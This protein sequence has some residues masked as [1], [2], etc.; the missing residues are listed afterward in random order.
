MSKKAKIIKAIA[1]IIQVVPLLVVLGIYSPVLVSRW[2][3]A[4][5]ISAIIVIILLAM[6]FRDATKK[7]L[8]RPS[9]FLF[10]GIIFVLCMISNSIGDQLLVISA[11]SLISGLIALPFNVWFNSL[12][13]PITKEDLKQVGE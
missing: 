12:T 13:R 1:I 6:I 5:S 8:Q 9:G 10:S 7:I 4:L 3:K 11:T 2:D